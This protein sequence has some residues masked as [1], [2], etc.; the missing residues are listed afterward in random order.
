MEYYHTPVLLDEVLGHLL[1]GQGK[2]FVDCTMGEGGHAVE[3]LKRGGSASVLIGIERDESS[4]EIARE[5]LKDWQSRVHFVHDSFKNIKKIVSRFD[6]AKV[7]GILFDLGISSRQLERP[8]RGFSFQHDGPLD[9]RMSRDQKTTAASLINTL[10][11]GDLA[12]VLKT[13]GEEKWARRIAKKI[14][15]ERDRKKINTTKELSDIVVSAVPA[16]SRSRKIH[17][18]TKTFQALRIVVNEELDILEVALNDA[19]ELLEE[20]GRICVISFHSLEDRIVKQTFHLYH[21]GCICPPKTPQCI[22]GKKPVLEILT[23][24]AV[25]PT[26]EEIRANPRARSAKLRA[27][28]KIVWKH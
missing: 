24:K 17:P 26:P 25:V 2:V 28:K 13:Y 22:C 1:S 19:V 15:A 5:R 8:E 23:K 9:M 16:F 7:D 10:S 3:I 12:K 11:C 14:V 27:A 18:A 4:M 21:K 6:I 20:G